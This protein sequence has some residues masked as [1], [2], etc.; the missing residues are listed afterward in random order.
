[1]HYSYTLN[2]HYVP[3]AVLGTDYRRMNKKKKKKRK[4]NKW[5]LPLAS[6]GYEQMSMTAQRRK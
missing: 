1:M 3:G 4:M 6:W 2:T 5:R